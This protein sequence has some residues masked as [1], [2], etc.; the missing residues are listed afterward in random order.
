M[1]APEPVSALIK[2]PVGQNPAAAPAS[3]AD[4]AIGNAQ[5]FEQSAQT[6]QPPAAKH[7]RGLFD[8]VDAL[9]GQDP[10]LSRQPPAGVGV[11]ETTARAGDAGA[12]DG[13]TTYSDDALESPVDAQSSAQADQPEEAPRPESQ[14]AQKSDPFLDAVRQAATENARRTEKKT[15]NALAF[16]AVDETASAHEDS[17]KTD[18]E[19]ETEPEETRTAKTSFRDRFRGLR[20]KD[21]AADEPLRATPVGEGPDVIELGPAMRIVDADF[22]DVA[23]DE[24]PLRAHTDG[25]AFDADLEPRD[26]EDEK[27][28]QDKG[29]QAGGK[30]AGRA[31]VKSSASAT[32]LASVDDLE[33]AAERVFNEEFFKALNLQ[34]REL[35][36][37][38]RKARRR[39]EARDKNRLTPLRVIGWLVWT[40]LVATS[41][42]A[43]YAYR[44]ELVDAWPGASAAYAAVG[45]DVAPQGLKILD[46]SQRLLTST[47]G[48][49]IEVT[50]RVLNDSQGPIEPPDLL[51]EAFDDAGALLSSWSFSL[52]PTVLHADADAPFTSR[53]PAPEDVSEIVITFASAAEAENAPAGLG[54]NADEV[55]ADAP[56]TP[57]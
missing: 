6:T 39:A 9:S 30:E 20:N 19:T 31:I 16:D 8:V 56:A 10:E 38:I 25:D 33:E 45:L 49:V 51:A 43:G 14:A 32:A 15:A 47:K 46:V 21:N 35:E 4:Q 2:K 50:G 57:E 48:P 36:K 24:P 40:G 1:P 52:E 3:E 13:S 11:D 26:E 53:A 29:A 7:G 37:A 22:E 42:I 18:K 34:P 5:T 12:L 28:S 17:L 23:K 27:A 55:P 41:A 44:Q 54:P